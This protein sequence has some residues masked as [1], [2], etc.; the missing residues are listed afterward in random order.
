MRRHETKVQPSRMSEATCG[1]EE[2]ASFVCMVV[3]RVEEH[4][5]T[6]ILPDTKY[7]L[8]GLDVGEY[9]TKCIATLPNSR[10]AL[11]FIGR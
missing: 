4:Q 5:S 11:R 10:C 3:N 8:G 9:K 6:R 2:S 1:I 7:S